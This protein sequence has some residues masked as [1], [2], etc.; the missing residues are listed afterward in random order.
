MY[1]TKTTLLQK[2]T[3]NDE[4]GFREFCDSY[5]GLIR[6]TAMKSG[7]PDA[8]TDDIIQAVMCGIFNNGNFLYSKE[9]HGLF[10]TYLGGII[11]HKIIDYFRNTLTAPENLPEN[12]NFCND[13]EKIFLAEYQSH[14]L[15]LAVNELRQK[16]SPEVFETF[17]LCFR[18]NLSDKEAAKLLG[19]KPNTVTIRK[20]RCIETMRSIIRQLQAADPELELP[21]L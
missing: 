9:K 6:S 18:R 4:I 15:E 16:V 11:R 17:E 21:I 3:D 19:E 13:L 20:K 1:T 12:E 2:L 14:I 10:R 7:V 5:S 8:D